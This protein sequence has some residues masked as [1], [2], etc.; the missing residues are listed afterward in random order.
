MRRVDPPGA[1]LH[2][3]ALGLGTM[4]RGEQTRAAGANL[5]AAPAATEAASARDPGPSTVL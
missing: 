1:S 3:A 5:A 2:L 4:A